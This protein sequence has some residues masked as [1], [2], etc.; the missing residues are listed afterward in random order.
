[1]TTGALR[2]APLGLALL[3]AAAHAA[4]VQVDESAFSGFEL[5]FGFEEFTPNSDV[6]ETQL[7]RLGVRF[8]STSNGGVPVEPYSDYSTEFVD[9]ALGAGAGA[10]GLIHDN[11]GEAIEFDPPVTRVGFLFGSNVPVD[12]PITVSRGGVGTSFHLVVAEDQLEFFGFEDPQGIDEIG[13]GTELNGPSSS[14]I[15][16]LRFEWDPGG[17]VTRIGPGAFSGSEAVLGFEAFTPDVDIV[18]DQFSGVTFFNQTD[19]GWPVESYSGYSD[20]LVDFALGAGRAPTDSSTGTL[21]RRSA[22][23]RRSRGPASC[24]ARTS[25]SGCR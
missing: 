1:M 22:S 21:V 24:S 6:V 10:N 20:A 23:T 11:D 19:G 9:F 2:A 13:F 7:E 8:S 25:M 17:S 5:R 4:V 3:G 15:D 18:S 16:E 14:Q 12:V